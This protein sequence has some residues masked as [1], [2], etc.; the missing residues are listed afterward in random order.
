MHLAAEEGHIE[1]VQRLA[2]WGA[3]MEARDQ[4]GASALAWGRVVDLV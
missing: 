1:V 3:D 2:S 4:V